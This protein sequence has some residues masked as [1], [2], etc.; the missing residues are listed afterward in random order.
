MT[1]HLLTREL[2]ELAASRAYWLMLLVTG[3]LVGHAFLDATSLYAEASGSGGG[4]SALAQGLNPLTGIVVPVLGAYD[5]VSTLLLPFVVIR[6]FA[7]DRESGALAF[8]LQAPSSFA[9]VV[10]CKGAALLIGW[11][12]AGIPGLVALTWWRVM[13]GH[14]FPPEVATVVA[15]HVLRGIL[16]IGVGAAAGA[17]AA[18]AASAAIVALSVTIGSWAVDYAAAA[19][20]GWFQVLAAYTPASAL[21]VFEQGELRW[22]VVLVLL[23]VGVAGIAVAW[24]WLRVG[25]PLVRR[26]LGVTGAMAALALVAVASG[27]IR[28]SSDLSED[29]RNS[30]SPADERALREIKAPL[31]I[32]VFL[33]A[34][35]PRLVDLERGVFAKLRRTLPDVHI[36]YQARGRSGLFARPGDH[37]GEVWYEVSGRRTMSR[38][39]TE[40]IVLPAI[41]EVAGVAQPTSEGGASYPGYPLA[42]LPRHAAEVF[43]VLWPLLVGFAWWRVQRP[44]RPTVSTS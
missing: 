29:R 25:R 3:L 14:L 21:R 28:A 9:T 31:L 15:G 4:P 20:G 36:A 33:A 37:Y 38:S 22:S 42:I 27:R 41:Y 7:S 2:R 34:E 10:A 30:F 39:A 8:M 26:V 12:V 40:E 43:F 5:L 17:I 44:P 35:D 13:G 6:I 11:L 19:R 16:T 1:A 18:N 32:A 24:E 23:A